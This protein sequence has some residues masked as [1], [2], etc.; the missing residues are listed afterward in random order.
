MKQLFI[1]LLLIVT[2]SAGSKA[3]ELPPLQDS[4]LKVVNALPADSSR[5][6]ML[7]SLA[8]QEPTSPSCAFYLGALLKEATHQNNKWF[9]GLAMYAYV[10]YYFNQQDAEN[11][12]GWMNKLSEVALKHKFYNLY[13]LGKRAEITIH[14]I[15][16][17]I[18]YSITEAEA[19]YNLAQKVNNK[20]GMSAAKLCLMI[21]YSMSARYDEGTAAG[22]EAYNLLPAHASLETRASILQEI[23]LSCFSTKD[24]SL[25][26][27]LQEYKSILN[28][29][30]KADSSTKDYRNSYLLM[31]SIYAGYYLEKGNVD[32][33]RAHLNKMDKLLSPQSYTPNRGLYYDVYSHY[34][35]LVREYDKALTCADSAIS[36]LSGISDNGGLNYRIKRAGILADKGQL[37]EAIPLFEE[38]LAKKDSFYRDLST[39]QME[40]IHQM[41]NMDDLLLEKEQHK[42]IIHYTM[43]GL[44]VMALLVLTPS[45]IRIYSVRKRLKK[46]EEKIREMTL[47]AEEANEVKSRFLANISYNIRTALNNVL[48][49]SQLMTNEADEVDASQW[50]TYSEI[51][52]SNSATLLQLVNNLLDLSR[53]E[54]GKTKWQIQDQDI[55]PLCSDVISIAQMRCEN[56]IRIDFHTEIESQPFQTDVPRFTQVLL[57]MLVP[58]NPY[59]EEKAITF[60]LNRKEDEKLLLF[61]IVN[62]PLADPAQQTQQTE[63]QHSINRLTIAHFGGSYTVEPHA[64]D[65]PTVLFTYS[66]R[67]IKQNT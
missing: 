14:I 65:G 60:S 32:E 52:Q 58:A 51:V 20:E 3:D 18:E 64:P 15:K 62:S 42:A 37:D 4:L 8:C 33:A 55:I 43:I 2:G 47:I 56:K 66:Y 23:T 63:V 17:R 41:R 12:V 61:R 1:F 54:A 19:M 25:L 28:K 24:K 59:E 30:T 29:L 45:A 31:E 36:L 21:A 26:K 10:V 50:Q 67:P 22:L 48:G 53:L 35:Q 57:S 16:H 9:Q 11:T 34:Y 46:E 39:S 49:F 44:I 27:Y 40:E 7:Y 13:F 6:E 38:L 5:L